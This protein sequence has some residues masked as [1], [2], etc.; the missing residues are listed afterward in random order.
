MGGGVIPP[1]LVDA[2]PSV[3]LVPHFP[4]GVLPLPQKAH[5]QQKKNF[6][7]DGSLIPNKLKKAATFSPSAAFGHLAVSPPTHT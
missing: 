4:P 7:S 6:L 1:N 3:Q 2:P 5:P